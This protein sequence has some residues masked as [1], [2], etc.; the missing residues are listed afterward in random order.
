M[1]IGNGLSL[2]YVLPSKPAIS[3]LGGSL[4]GLVCFTTKK[5]IKVALEV[6]SDV[7][8]IITNFTAPKICFVPYKVKHISAVNQ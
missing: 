1:N 4:Y 8:I 2:K 7:A 5:Q 3:L 6:Y